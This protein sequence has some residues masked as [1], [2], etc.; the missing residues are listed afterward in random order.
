MDW[1]KYKELNRE[2]RINNIGNNSVLNVGCMGFFCM[3]FVLNF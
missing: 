1:K 2:K 3:I